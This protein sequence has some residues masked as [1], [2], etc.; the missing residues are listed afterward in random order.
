MIIQNFQ[1]MLWCAMASLKLFKWELITWVI[2]TTAGRF[3]AKWLDHGGL[4]WPAILER[5]ESPGDRRILVSGNYQVTKDNCHTATHY[6]WDVD[7]VDVTD[8]FAQSW[9]LS[10]PVS[11]TSIVLITCPHTWNMITTFRLRIFTPKKIWRKVHISQQKLNGKICAKA[12]NL[13]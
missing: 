3:V 2:I 1:S 5:G 9:C 12:G 6:V 10:R 4:M 8:C 7:N 13:S 11:Q